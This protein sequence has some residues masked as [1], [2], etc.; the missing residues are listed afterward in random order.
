MG[1]LYAEIGP[2]KKTMEETMKNID[3]KVQEKLFM[4]MTYEGNALISQEDFAAIVSPWASFSATD[5]NND[6][7]L[8]I[9]ELKTLFWLMEAKEP[10]MMRVQM[11]M[12]AIDRDQSGTID[13]IEFISYL[14]S[15]G[16]KGVGYFDFE[17]RKAFEKFDRNRDGR[18]DSKELIE[19]LQFLLNHEF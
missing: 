1:T 7:E 6:N 3:F 10:D 13:R 17:L 9:M 2:L 8:D 19:F 11:E 16:E 15:P 14:V 18:L 4:L 12:D 5:I